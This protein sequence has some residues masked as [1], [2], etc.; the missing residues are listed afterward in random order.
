MTDFVNV[1]SLVLNLNEETFDCGVPLVNTY[2]YEAETTTEK[3]V[4]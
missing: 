1:N 4:F 3:S 2:L